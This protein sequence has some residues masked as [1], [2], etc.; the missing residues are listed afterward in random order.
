MP[1]AAPATPG[2]LVQSVGLVRSTRFEIEPSGP[3]IP[4][5]EPSEI[6][7]CQIVHASDIP[8]WPYFALGDANVFATPCGINLES[9]NIRSYACRHEAIDLPVLLLFIRHNVLFMPYNRRHGG[10]G[11]MAKEPIILTDQIVRRWR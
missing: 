10:W 2:R 7:V 6:P 4:P 11:P 9:D 8:A 5:V 1:P 3:G